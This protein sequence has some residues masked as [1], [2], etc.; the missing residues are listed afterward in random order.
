[1]VDT[2]ILCWWLHIVSRRCN[3]V[4]RQTCKRLS[5]TLHCTSRQFKMVL[6]SSIHSQNCSPAKYRLW[7]CSHQTFAGKWIHRT[8]AVVGIVPT[9]LSCCGRSSQVRLTDLR[10]T[11]P[12]HKWGSASR[13]AL[14]SVAPGPGYGPVAVRV[15]TDGKRRRGGGPALVPGPASVHFQRHGVSIILASPGAITEAALHW[16]RCARQVTG[17]SQPPWRGWACTSQ[18]W[19]M[20]SK[21]DKFFLLLL[22]FQH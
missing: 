20:I 1:M 6:C 17:G 10:P 11:L 22:F 8:K 12:P 3:M 7:L 9:W 13:V 4:R 5:S 14:P 19:R 21:S 2:C 15:L 16:H 18:R